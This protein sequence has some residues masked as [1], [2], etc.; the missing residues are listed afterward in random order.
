MRVA[1]CIFALGMDLA[2]ELDVAEDIAGDN[3]KNYQA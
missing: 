3:P 1:R 2:S